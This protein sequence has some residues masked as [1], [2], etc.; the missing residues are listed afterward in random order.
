MASIRSSKR[1]L[2]NIPKS[3]RIIQ[4]EDNNAIRAA[5]DAAVPPQKGYGGK[6]T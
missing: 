4:I 6:S 1:Q 3:I 2:L 5:A